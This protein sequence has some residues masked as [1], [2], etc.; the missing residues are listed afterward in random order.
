MAHY[1][2][3]ADLAAFRS[4]L[5]EH[6]D[7]PAILPLDPPVHPEPFGPFTFPGERAYGMPVSITWPG[8]GSYRPVSAAELDSLRAELIAARFREA[9]RYLTDLADRLEGLAR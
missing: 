2:T 3:S 4:W 8:F 7:S 1:P 5:R 6:P 9:E